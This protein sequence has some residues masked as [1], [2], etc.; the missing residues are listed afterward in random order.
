VADSGATGAWLMSVFHALSAGKT[1]QPATI[2]PLVTMNGALVEQT[3]PR[4]A[5]RRWR[6]SARRLRRLTRVVA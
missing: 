1:G 2:G 4:H 5:R 3:R 6:P